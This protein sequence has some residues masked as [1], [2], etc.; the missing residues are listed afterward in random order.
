MWKSAV[1]A[2]LPV[3]SVCVCVGGGGGACVCVCGGVNVPLHEKRK[4]RKKGREKKLLA[5]SV[6]VL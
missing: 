5:F 6:T 3:S 2:T 4:I 1:A